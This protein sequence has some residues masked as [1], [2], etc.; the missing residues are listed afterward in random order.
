MSAI[1][2][3]RIEMSEKLFEKIL[4]Q[5]VENNCPSKFGLPERASCEV[6]CEECWREAINPKI[7]E[8]KE[9]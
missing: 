5:L 1:K 6:G 7:I 3:V 8:G 9:G 4:E 2:T